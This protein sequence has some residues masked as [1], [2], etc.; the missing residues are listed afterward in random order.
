MFVSGPSG[1]IASPNEI[2][3]VPGVVKSDQPSGT[4]QVGS[5]SRRAPVFPIFSI[6]AARHY[7]MLHGRFVGKDSSDYPLSG[8]IN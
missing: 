2:I 8:D 4:N 6:M 3:N 7:L 1:P 5:S